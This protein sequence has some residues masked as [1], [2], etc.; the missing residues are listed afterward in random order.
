MPGVD[1]R[2]FPAPTQTV[3]FVTDT[4]REDARRQKN[5]TYT[6]PENLEKILQIVPDNKVLIAFLDGTDRQLIYKI[7]Q[8]FPEL[9]I[10]VPEDFVV[11]QN[12]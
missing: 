5:I 3:M 11:L 9:K 8:K 7:Q 6:T 10:K 4:F 12:Y 1:V 2:G